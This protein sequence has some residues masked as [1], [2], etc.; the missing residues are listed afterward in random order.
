MEPE[1]LLDI[2]RRSKLAPELIILTHAHADHI[3]G[4]DIIAGAFP[5]AKLCMHAAEADWLTDPE[6]NLS[7]FLGNPIALRTR[8]ARLL[9]HGDTL[10]LG[11]R[12]FTVLHTPGHSPGS[13]A[14]HSPV[15]ALAIVGDTL[16]AGSI[17]RTDFPHSDHEQLL[18]S[19]RQHLYTLPEATTLHPGHGPVTTVGHEKRTNP[20]VRA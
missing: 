13:L 11:D 12:A 7:V 16:F 4:L 15:D 2:V 1:P 6:L 14:L 8:P 18:A 17:G 19:I 20:F 3:A 5:A 9:A 10:T